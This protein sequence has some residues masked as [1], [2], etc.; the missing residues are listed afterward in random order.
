MTGRNF[1]AGM[2]GG[3]AYARRGRQ[4][5]E[6]LQPGAGGA[7]KVRAPIVTLPASRCISVVPMRSARRHRSPATPNIPAATAKAIWA[8]GRLREKFVAIYPH[9][10]KRA[11]TEML[12]LPKGEAA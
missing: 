12:P 10:V 11:L 2:S 8:T 7:E 3:I 1:A 5:Q 9:E 4:L 6:P